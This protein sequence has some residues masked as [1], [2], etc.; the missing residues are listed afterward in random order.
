MLQQIHKRMCQ[1]NLQQIDDIIIRSIFSFFFFH[2]L[3]FKLF[4]HTYVND[5]LY[6]GI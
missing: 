2:F 6:N 4:I 3:N 5:N 1:I